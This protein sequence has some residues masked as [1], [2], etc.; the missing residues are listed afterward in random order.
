MTPIVDYLTNF[1]HVAKAKI[2]EL[3][4]DAENQTQGRIF[5]E[6]LRSDKCRQLIK[7]YAR[8]HW[9]LYLATIKASP[10]SSDE[11]SIG[12]VTFE[13]LYRP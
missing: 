11:L 12:L 13:V 5:G 1:E 10:L 4:K 9:V 3:A 6:G 2:Q 7:D 8:F